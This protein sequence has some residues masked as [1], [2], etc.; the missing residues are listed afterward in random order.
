MNGQ[1]KKEIIV[2]EEQNF[3]LGAFSVYQMRFLHEHSFFLLLCSFFP[4]KLVDLLNSVLSVW[5][6]A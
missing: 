6:Y 2:I 3:F 4:P 5:A 1:K